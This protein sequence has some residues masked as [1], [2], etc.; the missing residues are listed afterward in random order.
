MNSRKLLPAAVCAALCAM[1]STVLAHDG[2]DDERD[3]WHGHRPADPKL[4]A[5]RQ[6]FF[7]IENVDS[8]GRVKKDK[9]IF[10]WATNTTYVASLGGRVMLLDSYINKP[11]LPTAPIDTRRSKV[12]PQ[13]FIDA[14]PEA[15]FLGHGHGDHA[16]NAAYVAKWTGATIYASPETCQVMQLDVARMWADPNLHNGGVRMIPDDRPVN[17]VG[18]VPAGSQPGEYTGTLANPTGGTTRVRRITQF[19]PQVCI[20]AFKFIHSGTAPVDASFPHTPLNNLGDPRYD[21]RVF[22]TPAV[23]YPA[24]FPTGMPFT[25][26][27]NAALR[28]PGQLNTTTT[29][30]GSPPGIPAGAIEIFYHFMLRDKNNFT[31]TWLNS[32]GPATE[33]IGSDPGLVTLAQY[34]DPV[35][36]GPAIA[37][38]GE[39][40]RS[41]YGL[42]DRLPG[43]DVLLG[44]IVSLGA[45]NN[46]Q[47]DI[48]K[49]IQ[50][51][52]P[53]VYYPGHTTDV[54]QPGSAM[55]HSI[56]WKQT[57]ANMGFPQAEWPE[58]R[59]QIDPNDFFVP[60]VFDPSDERWEK[61]HEFERQMDAICRH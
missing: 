48:I 5:A 13:D 10:S 29:G 24:M 8:R 38:A 60:Q 22:T 50:H 12:L 36:N 51:L 33:G 47:R 56:N 42:M 37:L 9:V 16:D 18:V 4:V 32:A 6:K 52:K 46:Q 20:V 14:R 43:P 53:R 35:N 21:G 3:G 41:L 39:V 23:T 15:I 7:G 40:G 45:T 28:V 30:F 57:A 31:V 34:N 27:N 55:Y 19:D 58:L 44:S 54:A 25:P 26:P 59:T 49:V 2:D 11:E 17:C 1:S 61:P